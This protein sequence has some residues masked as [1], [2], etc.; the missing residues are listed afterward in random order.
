MNTLATFFASIVALFSGLL[1]NT[2]DITKVQPVTNKQVMVATATNT[3]E[4]GVKNLQ[5]DTNSN[6]FTDP[7]SRYRVAIPDGMVYQYDKES[8]ILNLW[9]KKNHDSRV[10]FSISYLS[11][12]DWYDLQIPT[13]KEIDRN[14]ITKTGQRVVIYNPFITEACHEQAYISLKDGGA[15]SFYNTCGNTELKPF[16]NMII[17]GIELLPKPTSNNNEIING[18]SVPQEP[19]AN[20]NKKT[21]LGVDTNG[22][23]ARDDVER[24]MAGTSKKATFEEVMLKIGSLYNTLATE[25]FSSPLDVHIVYNKISCLDK[26]RSANERQTVLT[27]DILSLTANTPERDA[28]LL[29]NNTLL[30]NNP[31][32]QD[33]EVNCSAQ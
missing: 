15:L 6:T 23:G 28:I 32:L 29:F 8:K 12:A 18:I 11:K 27:A 1:G 25:R 14:V 20:L 4:V 19:D 21:L 30:A 2:Q 31:A 33:L 26:K 7:E 10:E 17:S 9:S 3:Q 5:Q 16:F 22:N 13:D 24:F